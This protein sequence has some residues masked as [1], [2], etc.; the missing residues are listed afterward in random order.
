[1]RRNDKDDQAASRSSR[2][3]RE[4]NRWFFN[5]RE[6]EAVGPFRDELEASTQLEV[7][8]RRADFGLLPRQ[9]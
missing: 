5:T 9:S 4:D 1:M 3:Y 8:I 6:G 2:M 7:Y